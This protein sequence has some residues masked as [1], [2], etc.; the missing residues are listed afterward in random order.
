MKFYYSFVHPFPPVEIIS[1]YTIS[2]SVFF[3]CLFACL[4]SIF[5]AQSVGGMEQLLLSSQ[6]A[7]TAGGTHSS[8]CLSKM[9]SIFFSEF[10]KFSPKLQH[11]LQ[12]LAAVETGGQVLQ[13]LMSD[14]NPN[15]KNPKLNCFKEVKDF[16]KK[17]E[18]H[19]SQY[20]VNR[21]LEY[22]ERKEPEQ[23]AKIMQTESKD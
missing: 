8:T 14:P 22:L 23:G 6:T 3:V 4:F 15:Q 9:C 20:C 17:A 18:K 2:R 21:Y 7:C 16:C 13:I 19:K 11:F 5:F 10:H 1:Y 12:E